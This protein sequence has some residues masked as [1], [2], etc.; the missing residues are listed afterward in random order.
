MNN[1]SHGKEVNF[2]PYLYA[3]L[4]IY[5]YINK[6]IINYNKYTKKFYYKC[7]MQLSCLNKL[8]CI[9]MLLCIRYI[10]HLSVRYIG[11]LIPLNV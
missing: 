6:Y 1:H 8:L 9:I 11:C 4:Y 7:V 3:L 2:A 10:I 5:I